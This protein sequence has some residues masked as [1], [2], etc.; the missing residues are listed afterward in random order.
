MKDFSKT[1]HAQKVWTLLEE[2][3]QAAKK[4]GWEF[5]CRE[6]QTLEHRIDMVQKYAHS[7]KTVLH[8]K[9]LKE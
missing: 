4:A 6:F 8:E 2:A 1:N 7:V 9:E 3:R 5:P